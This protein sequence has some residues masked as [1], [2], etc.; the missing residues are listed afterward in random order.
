LDASGGIG[1]TRAGPVKNRRLRHSPPSRLSG[2]SRGPGDEPI[3][4][5]VVGWQWTLTDVRPS[6]ELRTNGLT[7]RLSGESRNPR[8]VPIT[9]FVV[10]WQWTLT[11]ARPSTE[12]RTNGLTSRLSGESRNPRV[13]LITNSVPGG[14][15]IG[16]SFDGSESIET[17]DFSRSSRRAEGWIVSPTEIYTENLVPSRS[18][19]P[20]PMI[21]DPPR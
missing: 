5:F 18:N 15:S 14:Q 11:D 4:Y 17:L 1:G 19:R 16:T 6:T 7:S 2:E 20:F 21:E 12:L 8:V 9:Y 10:G 13:R 3:T